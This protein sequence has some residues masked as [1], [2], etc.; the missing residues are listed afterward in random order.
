M[1]LRKI[2]AWSNSNY[3]PRELFATSTICDGGAFK[4]VQ[5]YYDGDHIIATHPQAHLTVEDAAEMWIES[6][7]EVIIIEAELD[8]GR[9]V[10]KHRTDPAEYM[11]I[12]R[13]RRAYNG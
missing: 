10:Y 11:N 13:R 7:Y 6:D 8:D 1:K 2:E 5:S 4:S 12:I 3:K 9:V